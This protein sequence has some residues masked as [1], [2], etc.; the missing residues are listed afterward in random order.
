M[1]AAP[2]LWNRY[3]RVF[4]AESFF[5]WFKVVLMFH[6]DIYIDTSFLLSV[7]IYF[8]TYII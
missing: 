7:I 1:M 2:A 3:P 4:R 6:D 5:V 8:L